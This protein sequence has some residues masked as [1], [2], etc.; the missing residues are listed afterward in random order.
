[1][2]AAACVLA[3]LGRGMIL[4]RVARW[5]DVGERP[6][7][8]DY[9]L[10]LP[11]GEDT[12][13]FVAVAM[14]KRGLIHGVLIPPTVVSPDEMD[15]LV[16]PT[17]EIIR[18][19]L[20]MRGVDP[21]QVTLLEGRS[22]STWNDAE[23]LSRFLEAHSDVTVA[24]VTNTFH[25]RRSRWVFRRML[26]AHH[27]QFFFVSAPLDQFNAEDW[28]HYPDGCRTYL[29][30]YCKFAYYVVRYGDRWGWG[31]L[32]ITITVI[33]FRWQNSRDSVPSFRKPDDS[34]GPN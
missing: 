20:V 26:P 34:G 23:A 3:W 14:V 10:V 22:G 17:H 21:S 24:V 32:A 30:E 29:S 33:W 4:P 5:L 16:P 2:V 13:P 12:R 9:A 25:T 19:C 8:A 27:R 11:G 31:L 7:P 1:M 6:R 18:R 28:W 15:E